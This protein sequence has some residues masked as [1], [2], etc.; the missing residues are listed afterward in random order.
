MAHGW[1]GQKL[2]AVRRD[3]PGRS[4]ATSGARRG[5]IILSPLA[6]TAPDRHGL[7]ISKARDPPPERDLRQDSAEDCAW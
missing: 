6:A 4:K 7:S 3:P 1:D 5:W 2:E